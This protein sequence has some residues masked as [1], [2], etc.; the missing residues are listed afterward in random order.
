M[1]Y[2]RFMKTMKKLS[3]HLRTFKLTKV[4][5]LHL[6]VRDRL[7]RLLGMAPEDRSSP[8]ERYCATNGEMEMYLKQDGYHFVA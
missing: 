5:L 7:I 6:E 1:A 8:G 3:A 2:S 4:E